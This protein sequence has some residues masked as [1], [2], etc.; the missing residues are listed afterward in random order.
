MYGPSYQMQ[1]SKYME[2]RVLPK[3][4]SMLLPDIFRFQSC[5]FK[6]QSY[7][8]NCARLFCDKEVGVTY[9][10][11]LECSQQGFYTMDYAP[12]RAAMGE[13]T[14]FRHVK[15]FDQSSLMLIGTKMCEALHIL[16]EL[17]NVQ[18]LKRD[19]INKRRKQRTA[20]TKKGKKG[21]GAG[22]A[23][24]KGNNSETRTGDS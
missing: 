9:S 19:A 22:N 13:P 1:N 2:V 10:F 24:Q 16:N 14:T 21:K 11:C 20:K 17:C 15:Q 7:K 4:C 8:E 18:D 5:K 23:G 6:S 12:E 3:L